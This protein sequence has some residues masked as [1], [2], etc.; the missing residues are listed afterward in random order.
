[1]PKNTN[2]QKIGSAG[3][4]I[5]ETQIKLSEV[6]IARNL[7]EDFGID[8]ELEFSPTD[9]EVEGKFIKAQIKSHKKIEIHS[10]I[11]TESFSKSFLRYVYECRIPIILI[12]V[13][14][15]TSNSWY[16]WIQKWLIDSGNSTN[17]YDE[18]QNKSM[19]VQIN[20]ENDFKRALKRDL[21]SIASWENKTQLYIAVKD[22]ASLSLRMYDD[23]LSELLFG[24]LEELKSANPNDPDY[25][26]LLLN[27]V[28]E[29]GTGIWATNEGN[30]VSQMLFSFLRENGNKINADHISK[31]VIRGKDCSRT[32]IN[33]LGL[34]YD[35]YPEHTASLKLISRFKNFDDPRLF[36]YCSIR[37]RFLGTKSPSWLNEK[38]DLN[39]GKIKTD[40]SE[41]NTSIFDKWA[42]R[43]DSVIFDYVYFDGEKK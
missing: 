5:A 18:S 11:L 35:N 28:I 31:L 6:W 42:N 19:S 2:S 41:I 43:G 15:S 30:K 36:Y 14:T 1:M 10:G 26:D 8:I 33:A 22:L 3:H 7:T 32:G 9:D 27:R 29:L 13:E 23:K 40:F 24:Y 39:L 4:S 34:L 16:V 38:N 25:I 20:T 37:E 21:I 17:I 12:I